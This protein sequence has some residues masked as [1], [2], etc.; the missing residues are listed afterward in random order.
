MSWLIGVDVGGTFTDFFAFDL[1]TRRSRL[2]KR[3]S[4][5]ENPALA[6]V[7]GMQELCGELGVDSADVTRLCHGTTVAT[8]ALIQ[9]KGGRV[10][11]IT[12]KGFR[13]LLEIGR[14]TRPRMYDLQTDN[15]P[16][17]VERQDRFEIDE[18]IGADGLVRRAI[19]VSEIGDVAERI[20]HSG[21]EACAVCFLFSFLEP[22]H[23]QQA[24]AA[25][26][27]AGIDMPLSLSSEVHPEFREYERF[28]TTVLNAYLQ[29]VMER[30]L[31]YLQGE[32]RTSMPQAAVGIF[33]SSGGL[34]SVQ[35]ARKFPIRTALSGP[36]A[37]VLGA[38]QSGRESGRGRLIGLD[39]GGTSADICLIEDFRHFVSYERDVAGFPIRLASVDVHTVG[40]GGGSVAWFDRDGLL[41][42]GPKS[43]G[44]DPG[45]ACYGRGGSQATVTDANLL[46]G[47]LSPRG[48]LGGRMALQRAAAEASFR[49]LAAKLGF[50]ITRTALGV[51][52]IVT[53]NMVRAVRAISVERGHDPREYVLMPFGGAG[54]LHA[55]AAARALGITEMLVPVAP[56]IL[57]AQ[58]LIVSDLKEQFTATRRQRVTAADMG[59]SM[60]E[61]TLVA[62][63]LRQRA[64]RWFD[65]EN[66]APDE[67]RHTLSLDMRYV[68]QNFELQVPL[69]DAL[70]KL[71]RLP[72]AERLL[73]LFFQAHEQQY[74]FHN[75][76]DA[77][78][79]ITVR[80]VASAQ[81]AAIERIA[82]TSPDSAPDPEP[83][84]Q[85]PVYFT[86]ADAA[87][88]SVYARAS[89][90]C[91]DR[92]E[93]PVVIEQLD[94]T[95]LLFP[96]DRLTVD[97]ALNL[98]I[99]LRQ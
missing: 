99:E 73:V 65:D 1:D 26:R 78:E 75:P 92:L 4:T 86:D 46:L 66:I 82:T 67:R 74:G 90:R 43:A 54:P 16:P 17:L 44:A 32:L 95:T 42:V 7:L 19:D 15:P 5:P 41:K 18:R 27:G 60:G 45:P 58:G 77:V 6:I 56:G 48:L 35:Q 69:G 24:A 28:S 72:T 12:S 30:Y 76:D 2:Y 3:P 96:G 62:D 94:A 84:E 55:T 51:L 80:L 70:G 34:M 71:P 21:A 36:A 14:Q 63:G 59:E 91:G 38:V 83:I 13:D 97:D 22:G 37:G 85:R 89:L 88:T 68:G 29:P 39:M 33:Q 25:L 50:S 98:S 8:N 57:C 49:P 87:L 93:G 31:G 53:A 20:K 23:E 47:R 81:L 64:Q 40:A 11:M 10:A 61:L 9:R 79:V 52:D